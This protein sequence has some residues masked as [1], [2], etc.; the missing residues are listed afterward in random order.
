MKYCPECGKEFKNG[1]FCGECGKP[2]YEKAQVDNEYPDCVFDTD[3]GNPLAAFES[4]TNTATEA[5]QSSGDWNAIFKRVQQA[6]ADSKA[7]DTAK[8]L[9]AFDVEKLSNGKYILK[10]LKNKKDMEVTV[11][12][13]VQIIGA[14]AFAESDVNSVTLPEGL[15]K[16]EKLAFANCADLESINFPS[17]LR[18]IEEGAFSGCSSLDITAPKNIRVGKDAFKNTLPFIREAKA[19]AERE[20]ER[21]RK[22][23]AERAEAERKRKEAEAKAAEEKR[24]K[25]AAEKA[26]AERKR[27]EAEAKAAEDKRRRDAEI[28]A[29]K[30]RKAAEERKQKEATEKKARDE[31]N[32]Y[33]RKAKSGDA[34]AQMWLGDHIFQEDEES[35][36]EWYQK[37]ADQG[38]AA[39]Q[40]KLGECYEYGFGVSESDSKAAEYYFKAVNQGYADALFSLALCLETGKGIIKDKNE[41]LDYYKQA[42]KK[43]NETAQQRAIELQSEIEALDDVSIIANTSVWGTI[44][45]GNYPQNDLKKKEPIEWIVL[46]KEYGRALLLSKYVLFAHEYIDLYDY[47]GYRSAEFKQRYGYDRYYDARNGRWESHLWS[48]STLRQHLNNQF[49]SEAFNIAE[50]ELICAEELST[51]HLLRGLYN[52]EVYAEE[53]E[54]KIFVLDANDIELLFG[55]LHKN[56]LKAKPTSYAIRNGVSVEHGHSPWWL[57]SVYQ[58]AG[59]SNKLWVRCVAED[60][61]TKGYDSEASKKEVSTFGVRPAIWV[62]YE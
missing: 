32:S 42:A 52:H 7:Q 10:A 47:V 48:L 1:K 37:A 3:V 24:K 13:C 44:T 31:Y 55:F 17:S 22:E 39:A 49:I 54:D 35:A 62:K 60:G 58:T 14:N 15:A 59:A 23:Q 34:E 38:L 27:K 16:I 41:A 5:K 26:E 29:E 19:A 4:N 2:L 21:K 12:D 51:S 30:E 56:L 11:P 18:I 28:R 43:G 36:V 40:H 8:A 33:E 25:E 45:F 50:Q 9:E 57:R 61:K 53:T 20:A 6:S 46:K